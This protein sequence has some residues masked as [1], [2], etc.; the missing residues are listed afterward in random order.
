MAT[1]MLTLHNVLAVLRDYAVEARNLYQD[2]LVRH[3]RIASGELLN[4]AECRVSIG[5]RSYDVILTL[6]DYWCYVEEDTR[7]HWPPMDAI[8]RWIQIKPVL[9][10]P[11]A[12]GRIPTPRQ[13]AYLIGRKIARE[14]T[15]GSHD[16][17]D[18]VRQMNERY[19]ERLSEAL[20][21]DVSDY[22]TYVFTNTAD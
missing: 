13:L 12:D 19:S 22:I 3:G 9:P 2:N 16:L 5:D 6:Q 21:K 4:T 8:L 18:A 10:R 15:K 7:P 14:G 1:E 20:G 17:A 11:D